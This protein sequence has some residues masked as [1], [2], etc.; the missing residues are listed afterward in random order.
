MPEISSQKIFIEVES[1][2][3]SEAA[4][5]DIKPLKLPREIGWPLW[6][7]GLIFAG[8]GGGVFGGIWLYR[9]RFA[10]KEKLGMVSAV[11]PR[12]PE[13]VAYELLAKLDPVDFMKKGRLKE[14]YI[15]LSEIFRQYLEGRFRIPAMDLTTEE[16]YSGLREIK[17]PRKSTGLLEG[18]LDECDLVKFAKYVPGEEQVKKSPEKAKQIIDL[19]TEKK[20]TAD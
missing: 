20:E 8:I 15:R 6:V 13:E 17:I 1:V 14:F 4:K 2:A 16:I 10:V 18:F 5:E 12:S 9:K 3:P 11:P 19:T 7:W